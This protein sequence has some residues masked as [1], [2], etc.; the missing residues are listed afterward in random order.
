MD[1]VI[2]R[3]LIYISLII[4][5]FSSGIFEMAILSIYNGNGR[6]S[7]GE[8]CVGTKEYCN[9]QCRTFVSACLLQHTTNVPELPECIFGN[10]STAVLGGNVILS[11]TLN[12]FELSTLLIRFQFSWPAVFTLVVDVRHDNDNHLSQNDSSQLIIRSIVSE[13]IY[14]PSYWYTQT[15]LGENKSIQYTYRVICDDNYYGAG[16][17][18]FCR[19]RNDS[20]GHYVCDQDGTKL[21]LPGWDGEFCQTAMCW[22]RCNMSHG[23]CYE[24]FQCSCFIGW[25]GESCDQCIRNPGCINGYCH[26]PWQCICNGDWTG[27]DCNIDINY[28][29]KY[30]PCEHSG[31]CLPD[32]QKN[33]TCECVTGYTGTSCE[34]VICED[35]H[36]QN[37]GNCSVSSIGCECP[38]KYYGPHCEFRKLTCD[39]TDCMNGGT[40][41]PTL[42]GT[43]CN[44][45]KGFTGEN[46]KSE[47]DECNSSPC[48]YG[49]IC[50]D[51][52]D[53]YICDCRDGYTGNNCDI[54]MDP[55]MGTTC[56]HNGTCVASSSGFSGSCLCSQGYTGHRCEIVINPCTDVECQNGAQCRSVSSG[57][58]FQ[59]I[60]PVGYNGAFCENRLDPCQYIICDN[61]G[62]CKSYIT[63][64][65]CICNPHYGGKHCTS[66]LMPADETISERPGSDI[67][68]VVKNGACSNFRISYITLFLVFLFSYVNLFPVFSRRI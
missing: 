12:D 7:D 38:E 4:Q 3:G 47:I 63:H 67:I 58:G 52:V 49:G 15:T 59:C 48:K 9:D 61:G 26:E 30:D 20:F 33:F 65:I 55:C 27:K 53:G 36:C 5:V 28:C 41:I 56:F 14:P 57:L 45:T 37:G 13:T 42:T 66:F 21:C 1:G 46:C 22:D 29:N 62:T 68:P 51:G 10:S 44:C 40:C 39:E 31:T 54:I 2:T 43:M 16:C 17:E 8:C 23:F 50:K 60:C 11:Q 24:P 35:R 32:N 25:E 6:R 34:S 18:V 64:Y 19:S